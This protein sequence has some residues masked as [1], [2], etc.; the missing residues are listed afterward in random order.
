MGETYISCFQCHLLFT[1]KEKYLQRFKNEDQN[2]V[3]LDFI[4]INNGYNLQQIKDIKGCSDD[5]GFHKLNWISN[6]DR[7]S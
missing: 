7:S 1:M 3:C 2:V 6:K 4:I 5:W